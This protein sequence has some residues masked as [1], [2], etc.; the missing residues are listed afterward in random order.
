MLLPQLSLNTQ[1]LLKLFFTCTA[2][3]GTFL[4]YST[5]HY[6]RIYESGAWHELYYKHQ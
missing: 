1:K 3:R 4:G 5:V 6:K 2:R